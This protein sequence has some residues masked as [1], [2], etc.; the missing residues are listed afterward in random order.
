MDTTL[1]LTQ[2]YVPHR[3]VS[4]Q[5][6][7]TMLFDDKVEVVQA[8]DDQLIRSPSLTIEMPAVVRLLKGV[9]QRQ[10]GVK[11]SRSNVLARDAWQ[12]QYCG[13]K[14]PLK[15]LTF[16]HV[17]PR[18]QGGRTFWENIVTACIRCNEKK[19]AR[20]PAEA[21]MTLRQKPHRPRELPLLHLH[22]QLGWR[23][24]DAWKSWVWTENES[25]RIAS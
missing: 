25:N 1:V 12:C 2:G 19:G 20:T 22:L 3:I 14:A 24:P 4:W 11:F 18:A 8:Y 10:K 15:E 5:K 6:A 16:D 17:I 21:R 9:R 13:D 23:V 7:V